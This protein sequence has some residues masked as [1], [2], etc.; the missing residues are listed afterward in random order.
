MIIIYRCVETPPFSTFMLKSLSQ[1]DTKQRIFERKNRKH[2]FFK[3]L[4]FQLEI[5]NVSKQKTPYCKR[6]AVGWNRHLS[7]PWS[8][9]CACDVRCCEWCVGRVFESVFSPVKINFFRAVVISGGA[10]ERSG[11]GKFSGESEVTG[12]TFM[13]NIQTVW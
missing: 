13:N 10:S 11:F 5:F 1:L 6:C 9:W 2:E 12:Q 8:H 3:L 7:S 4:R